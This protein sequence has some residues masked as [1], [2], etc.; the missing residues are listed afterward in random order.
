MTK[1]AEAVNEP[2]NE[3]TFAPREEEKAQPKSNRPVMAVVELDEQAY[4][5]LFNMVHNKDLQVSMVLAG[6]VDRLQKRV[7]AAGMA[8]GFVK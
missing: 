1:K 3:G 4:K 7:I 5:F 6:T 8:A 2:E